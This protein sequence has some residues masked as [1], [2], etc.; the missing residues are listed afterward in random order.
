MI[1]YAEQEFSFDFTQY[2]GHGHVVLQDKVV[3]VIRTTIVW[4]ITVKELPGRS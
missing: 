1:I 4:R 3:L 2:L